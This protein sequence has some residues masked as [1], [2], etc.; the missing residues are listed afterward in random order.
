MCVTFPVRV[1]SSPPWI[2][3]AKS[4]GH[5]HLDT[6][7][8]GKEMLTQLRVSVCPRR[9]ISKNIQ[10]SLDECLWISESR[11]CHHKGLNKKVGNGEAAASPVDN[12][13]APCVV[14]G[15]VTSHRQCNY[16]LD[17]WKMK[18]QPCVW[19][20]RRQPKV[21]A[22]SRTSALCVAGKLALFSLETMDLKTS[23]F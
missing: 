11:D 4:I 22:M 23:I 7:L 19:L 16:L 15:K 14:H 12:C 5:T 1:A 9:E 20:P 2:P 8:Q 21:L 18:L 10:T 3:A 6:I 13:L 17:K